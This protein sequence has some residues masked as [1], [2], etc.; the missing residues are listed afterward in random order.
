MVKVTEVSEGE[1]QKKREGMVVNEDGM[2]MNC[3]MP[4]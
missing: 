2:V 4:L 3:W 1:S